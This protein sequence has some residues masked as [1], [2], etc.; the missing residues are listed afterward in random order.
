MDCQ[1]EHF[2]QLKDWLRHEISTLKRINSEVGL[3]DEG[4]G[5]LV[6]FQVTLDF[7]EEPRRL[8]GRH[9]HVIK[10]DSKA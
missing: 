6:A 7:A 5:H 10:N 8:R 4:F 1:C 9:L 2:K 3:T